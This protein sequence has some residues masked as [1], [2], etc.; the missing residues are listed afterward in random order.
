ML[1]NVIHIGYSK[2]M[3][4]WF[5]NYFSNHPDVFLIRKTRFFFPSY[6]LYSKG[7]GYYEQFFRDAEGYPVIMESDEHLVLPGV[8]ESV[9]VNITNLPLIEETLNRI[10]N[11]VPNVKIIVII[12]NQVD[13]LISRYTEYIRGGGN[14]DVD[15]FLDQLVYNSSY[16][17]Y[18]DYRY[19]HVL[20]LLHS[21]FKKENVHLIMLEDFKDD[22]VKVFESLSS[23]LGVQVREREKNDRKGVYVSPS[24]YGVTAQ[25]IWNKMMVT[26]KKTNTEMAQTRIPA[27]LWEFIRKVIEKIDRTIIKNKQKRKIIGNEN[28][29]KIQQLFARDNYELGEM[30]ERDM[31]KLGYFC[32]KK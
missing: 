6:D 11:T 26:R 5:Q 24:Y 17:K 27:N 3:S 15:D 1:P 18:M 9:L 4:S 19:N 29:N 28:I 13:V 14:L 20:E 31:E 25:K 23:F 12:R 10:K 21:I 32:E 30:I 7:T 2:S 22:P 8:H 16:K